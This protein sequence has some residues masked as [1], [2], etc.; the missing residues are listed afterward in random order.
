MNSSPPPQDAPAQA[1]TPGLHPGRTFQVPENVKHLDSLQLAELTRAF[2]AWTRAG[3]GPARRRARGRLW[4]VYLLLRHT[5]AKIGEILSLDDTTDLDLERAVVRLPGPGPE[6]REL[7]LP[8]DAVAALKTYLDAPDNAAL[9]GQ[10]FRLDQ[11]YVRRTFQEVFAAAGLSKDLANPSV[12]RRSRAIELLRDG[13]PLKVIQVLF[14]YSSTQ[15]VAG[16]LDFSNEEVRRLVGRQLQKENRRRT[17][18]RNAFFGK[19]TRIKAGDIQCEIELTTLS[20]HNV[21]AVI[22]R[23]SLKSL[24]LAEDMYCTAQ[25]KAPWV[26]LAP[27]GEVTKTSARNRFPGTVTSIERG[28]I[29]CEIVIELPGG[30]EVC[31]LIT[32]QSLDNLK[33]EVG[34]PAVALVE[35]F[36]VILTVE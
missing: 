9:K 22:T 29:T 25:I 19:I 34:A 18:A 3:R 35:A 36:A 27:A 21:V 1:G 4:L 6:G 8:Q 11:G 28:D 14:G 16:F 23:G 5:G 24:G 2:A 13:M 32:R 31:S 17:S 7:A 26:I 12:L 20:G 10:V 30:L 15:Q 33:L